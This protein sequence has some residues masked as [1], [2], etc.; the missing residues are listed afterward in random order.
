[1]SLGNCA[2]RTRAPSQALSVCAECFPST[3]KSSLPSLLDL[4]NTQLSLAL[5][6]YHHAYLS[7]TADFDI[8]VTEDEDASSVPS[9]LPGFVVTVFEFLAGAVRLKAAKKLYIAN[10]QPT[11]LLQ[12][13]IESVMAYGQ[14]TTDEEDDFATN[15][16]AFVADEDDE[17]AAYSVRAAANDF[18]IVSFCPSRTC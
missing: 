10:K 4:T 6:V 8:P 18:T 13:S 2:D 15:P 9:D 17:A 7:S 16:N 14:M 11:E 3:V 1:M 5:P 12:L